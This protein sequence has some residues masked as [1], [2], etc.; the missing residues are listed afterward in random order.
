MEIDILFERP[1]PGGRADVTCNWE[2]KHRP[3]GDGDYLKRSIQFQM[4]VEVAEAMVL[5]P[6][7]ST[8]QLSHT[9]ETMNK[10]RY[11]N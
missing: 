1:A 11:K 2:S 3:L 6:G 8:R 9:N 7:I 4:A 5:V 10:S